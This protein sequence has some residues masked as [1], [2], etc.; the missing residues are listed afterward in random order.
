MTPSTSCIEEPTSSRKCR[1]SDTPG[2]PAGQ[3]NVNDLSRAVREAGWHMRSE[4]SIVGCIYLAIANQVKMAQN[5]CI[6]NC[7]TYQPNS[8]YT[9]HSAHR[10]GKIPGLRS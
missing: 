3:L 6:C 2:A 5:I 10:K 9:D 7:N 4:Q 1:E 8:C